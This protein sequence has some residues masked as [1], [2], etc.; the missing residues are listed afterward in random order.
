M[1]ATMRDPRVNRLLGAL[2]QAELDGL[3]PHLHIAHYPARSI[4]YGAGVQLR[5]IYFPLTGVDSVIATMADGAVAEVGTVGNEGV[6]G[7]PA[8]YGGD[9]SPFET[10]VQ[11]PGQF[12]RLAIEPFQEALRPETTLYTLIQ[13]YA[14]AYSVLVGQSAACNR[15]HPV[16]ER[17]ARWLLLTHDRA[18][19]DTFSLSQEFLGY[20]LGTRRASVTVAAGMLQHAGLITYHRGIITDTNRNGLE[21]AA[22]ECYGVITAAFARYLPT[23]EPS[24]PYVSD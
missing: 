6:V 4:L 11:V 5:D 1:P 15:L 22:C 23:A 18:G 10:I 12:A 9:H 16:E 8:F 24:Q 2:P 20:I 7:L 13:R 21:A 3:R 14:L 19:M 17:C